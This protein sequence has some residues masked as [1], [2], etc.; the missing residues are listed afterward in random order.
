M[1]QQPIRSDLN[2]RE[3][4]SS[5]GSSSSSDDDDD[6]AV[7]GG[8]SCDSGRDRGDDSGGRM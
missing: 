3:L 8:G 5:G 6:D 4:G 7:G 1:I 2:G